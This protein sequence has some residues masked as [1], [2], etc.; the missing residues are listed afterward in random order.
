MITT[1]IVQ[2]R[3]RRRK[4]EEKTKNEKF[5]EGRE[6]KRIGF[7]SFHPRYMFNNLIP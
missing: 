6:E 5:F 4:L 1:A 3:H 2:I 7:Q